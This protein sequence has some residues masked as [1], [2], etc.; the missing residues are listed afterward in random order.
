ML[1]MIPP[2]NLPAIGKSGRVGP[3]AFPGG[4][5]LNPY[6]NYWQPWYHHTITSKPAPNPYPYDAGLTLRYAM[7]DILNLWH[8]MSAAQKAAWEP[9]AR[10]SRL[11]PYHEYMSAN[12]HRALAHQP[13]TPTP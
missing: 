10:R 1:P 7:A 13:P 11:A 6:Y 2:P 9:R 5:P 12:I 4:P 3:H 8:E